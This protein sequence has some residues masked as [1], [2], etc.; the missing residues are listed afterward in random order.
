MACANSP[1][2]TRRERP[3]TRE[4]RPFSL[5]R[6]VGFAAC[7]VTMGTMSAS[8]IGTVRAYALP[9]LQ[10]PPQRPAQRTLLA[11]PRQS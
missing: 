4:K 3:E 10:L 6:C 11:D 1:L 9:T 7:A 2:S 5:T 8:I